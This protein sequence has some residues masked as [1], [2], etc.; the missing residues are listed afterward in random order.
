MNFLLINS[1]ENDAFAAVYDSGKLHVVK[2][3][4]FAPKTG[5][6]PDK[7]IYCLAKLREQFD[8]T[9]IDAVS[10]TTGPGS[11][12]GIRVGLSFAKGISAAA[13]RPVIPVNSFDLLLEQVT[14]RSTENK[15]CVLIPAKKPEYYFALYE[16]AVQIKTGSG[17]IEEIA[18]ICGENTILVVN[19]DDESVK[20]HPYFTFLNP[21]NF[22]PDTMLDLTQK[23]YASGRLFE[24]GKIEP[25]YIKEFIIKNDNKRN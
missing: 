17:L 5:R 16:G 19:F 1:N 2:A 18:S 20:K 6:S 22:E 24:P 7:L 4:E 12:T 25:V 13:G 9:N 23:Y 10:V 8:F 3:S 15:Y 11:F 14:G 21:N